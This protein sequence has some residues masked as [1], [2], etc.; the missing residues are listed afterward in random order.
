[1]NDVISKKADAE[2]LE[3]LAH[4]VDM[5]ADS[6]S[7]LWNQMAEMKANRRFAWLS[8]CDLVLI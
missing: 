5:K 1:M 3:N 6:D 2:M 4:A 7:A 8:Y